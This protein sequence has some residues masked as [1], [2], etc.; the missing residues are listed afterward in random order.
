[1]KYLLFLIIIVFC[2]CHQKNQSLVTNYGFA[3]GTSYSIKYMSDGYDFHSQIDSLF[4]EV[5]SSLSTYVDF[6]IVSQLNSGDTLVLLDSHFVN[7]FNGAVLVS[8]QTNGLF[9][10][11]V[12]PLVNAW[13]FGPKQIELKIDS[14]QIDDIAKK[15]GY[16]KV[17]IK[18]D[19]LISNP[20]QLSLDFNAIAQGYTVDLI[21][22]FLESK[23]I[24]NYLVEVG[25]E[26]RSKG[27]NAMRK[28]WLIGIDKPTNDIDRNDR[29]QVKVHLSNQSLA[30]SGNYRRY[31][32]NEGQLFSHTI[33]PKTG[34]PVKHSLLSAT[35]ITN[36]CMM[37]DA[38]A[39]A[40]MVM[41]VKETQ[42]FLQNRSD[43]QCM[44]IYTDRNKKWKSWYSDGFDELLVK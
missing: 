10:C 44:L 21:A 37:A 24:T 35:V 12:A 42:Q 30:T 40:F 13:G 8:S 1:M 23:N 16:Q 41:G 3:Q 25:G 29:F 26:L 11:T 22:R 2:S 28:K 4:L 15:I 18:N 34:F 31:Y 32:E 33:H 36:D 43:I 17:I 5:D 19:S 9:D 27:L 14:S 20:E 6:S 39:T 38:Y 7:V